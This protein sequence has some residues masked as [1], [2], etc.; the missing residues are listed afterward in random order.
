VRRTSWARAAVQEGQEHHGLGHPSD[1]PL[2]ST[3]ICTRLAC[4]A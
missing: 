2:P 3:L 4:Q 1:A